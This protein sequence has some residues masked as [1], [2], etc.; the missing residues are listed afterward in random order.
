MN[1]LQF[2]DKIVLLSNNIKE[3]RMTAEGLSIE[4]ERVGLMMNTAKT[5]V[6]TNIQ[7]ERF[8]VGEKEIEVVEE[9]NYHGQMIAFEGKGKVE[10]RAIK[11]KVW[12]NF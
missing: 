12:K 9:Y 7:A 2:A 11:A 6:M 3:L 8:E 5:K 10:Q 4:S 1:N